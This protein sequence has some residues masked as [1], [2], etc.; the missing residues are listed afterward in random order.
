MSDLGFMQRPEGFARGELV[1]SA[2]GCTANIGTQSPQLPVLI[3]GPDRLG[4]EAK[5]SWNHEELAGPGL[6]LRVAIGELQG[7]KRGT[8]RALE[9]GL[10]GSMGQLIAQGMLAMCQVRQVAGD[11]NRGVAL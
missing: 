6:A 10:W 9:W 8:H 1:T 11:S 7:A 4:P 3:C 2:I 5:R